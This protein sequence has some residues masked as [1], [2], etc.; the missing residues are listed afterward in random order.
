MEIC[1]DRL[2][3]DVYQDVFDFHKKFGCLIGSTPAI[4]DFGTANLRIRLIEE[5]FEELTAALEQGDLIEVADAIADLQYVI[6]GTAISYGI[7]MR[8]IWDEVH[9]TNMAKV[10][11]GRRGDGKIMKPAGWQPPR[12]AEMLDAQSPLLQNCKGESHES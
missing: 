3:R 6:I 11:G 12:I 5:E 7:D 9:R 1:Q 8:P 10:D 4:P 2:N